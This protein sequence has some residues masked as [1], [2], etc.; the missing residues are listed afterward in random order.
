MTEKRCAT[1]THWYPKRLWDGAPRGYGRCHLVPGIETDHDDACG[2]WT[3]QPTPV[4]PP[5]P[6]RVSIRGGG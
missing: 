2:D 6:P 3:P 4:L 1:C 5:P